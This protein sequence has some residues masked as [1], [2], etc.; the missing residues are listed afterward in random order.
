MQRLLAWEEDNREKVIQE[1]SSHGCSC[2]GRAVGDVAID[3]VENPDEQLNVV[4]DG[5][6]NPD[7]EPCGRRG[8]MCIF[9]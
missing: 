4:I 3:G 6:E 2:W 1:R 7:E 9:Q 8:G 5:V